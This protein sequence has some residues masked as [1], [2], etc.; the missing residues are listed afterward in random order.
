[1][2]MIELVMLRDEERIHWRHVKWRYFFVFHL[3]I[4][5]V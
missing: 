4:C 1:M 3:W 5:N 2:T